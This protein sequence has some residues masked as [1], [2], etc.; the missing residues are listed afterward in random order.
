MSTPEE[1]WAE[2]ER[3]SLTF[4]N[5]I[6]HEYAERWRRYIATLPPEM[7]KTHRFHILDVG[8]DASLEEIADK[9]EQDPAFA[10]KIASQFAR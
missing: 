5:D 8:V 1:A 7:V 3:L 6:R 9:I 4:A 10:A 2:V